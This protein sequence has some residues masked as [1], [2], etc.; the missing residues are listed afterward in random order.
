M[1]GRD[2]VVITGEIAVGVPRAGRDGGLDDVLTRGRHGERVTGVE[3]G[4]VD[5]GQP[6]SGQLAEVGLVRVP[7]QH[8]SRVGQRR[9]G[10]HPLGPGQELVVAVVI[11]PGRAHDDQVVA[12]IVDVRVGPDR[13]LGRDAARRE[14][15]KQHRAVVVEVGKLGRGRDGDAGGH[16]VDP[17]QSGRRTFAAS[18]RRRPGRAGSS[19]AAPR[20]VRSRT[21][22][23][24]APQPRCRRAPRAAPRPPRVAAPHRAPVSSSAPTPPPCWCAATAT[25]CTSAVCRVANSPA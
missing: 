15:S 10:A 14:G 2:V 7:A 19:R 5:D 11:V 23:R 6:H 21:A 24:A 4:R 18:R 17:M 16:A 25:V 13:D 22:C 20:C 9:R 8:L 3:P 12:R 1:V